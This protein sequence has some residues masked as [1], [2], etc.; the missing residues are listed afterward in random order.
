MALDDRAMDELIATALR[1]DGVVRTWQELLVPVLTGIGD[2]YAG[3]GTCIEVEHLLSARVLAVLGGLVAR[4]V[5]AVNGRPVLLSCAAEEQHGLPLYALGAAL[6]EEGIALRLLGPG[7]PY[8]ALAGAI[9]RTGPGAV[10]VWSQ[11]SASGDPAPLAGLPAR[12]PAL[13]LIVGGP[14]WAH[15]RLPDGVRAVH[16]LPEAIAA[17]RAALGLT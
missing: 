10:F 5:E 17:V 8:P 2:R 4:P 12:R 7:M 9:E 6:T 3:T 15:D 13:R 1:R 14:G 11:T 16:S